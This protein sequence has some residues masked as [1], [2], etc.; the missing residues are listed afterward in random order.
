MA[1]KKNMKILKEGKKVVPNLK[2]VVRTAIKDTKR[3]YPY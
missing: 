3:S 2:R 1:C